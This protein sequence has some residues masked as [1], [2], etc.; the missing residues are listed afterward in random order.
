[1]LQVDKEPRITKQALTLEGERGSSVG[2]FMLLY[3]L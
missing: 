2:V 1:M 3:K